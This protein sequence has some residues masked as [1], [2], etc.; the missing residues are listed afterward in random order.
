MG[1][2]GKLSRGMKWYLKNRDA[3]GNLKVVISDD[4]DKM[5]DVNYYLDYIKG[6]DKDAVH[7]AL[8][9]IFLLRQAAGGVRSQL[10]KDLKKKIDDGKFVVEI[11]SKEKK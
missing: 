2:I 8:H 5:L 6:K 7:L 4:S 9:Q 3:D 11:K 10:F 1:H